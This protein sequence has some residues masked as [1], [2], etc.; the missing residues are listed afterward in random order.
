[1]LHRPLMST[2]L[3]TIGPHL[4]SATIVARQQFVQT[5]GAQLFAGWCSSKA[6]AVQMHLLWW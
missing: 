5:S 6:C 4:M 2:T 3:Q 1:M